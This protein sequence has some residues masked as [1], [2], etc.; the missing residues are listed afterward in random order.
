MLARLAASVAGSPTAPRCWPARARPRASAGRVTAERGLAGGVQLEHRPLTRNSARGSRPRA[1]PSRSCR[2]AARAAT[3]SSARS[4]TTSSATSATPAARASP[5]PT[6]RH[7]RAH[8]AMLDRR[9]VRRRT[10]VF[11]R[12][13]SRHR[14]DPDRDAADPRRTPPAPRRRRRDTPRAR[15]GACTSSSPT[16]KPSWPALLPQNL[17]VQLYRALLEIAGVEQGAA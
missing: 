13:Q 3:T 16:R 6:R 15:L 17:A 1:R 5:S 4:G 10:V 12:F 7:R 2:S 9:R 11:N 14:P 8:L